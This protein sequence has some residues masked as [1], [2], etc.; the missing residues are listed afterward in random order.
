MERP[1]VSTGVVRTVV[2]AAVAASVLSGCAGPDYTYVRDDTGGT[3]FKV[4]ASWR[5]IDQKTLDEELFGDTDSATAQVVKQLVWTAAFDAYEE[6]SLLHLVRGSAGTDDRPFV[7]AK[8]QKLSEEEQNAASLNLLRVSPPMPVP[9]TEDQQK[10]FEASGL[11]GFEL[12]AD[13][14]LPIADGVRGIHTVY[15]YR[16]GNAV[17]TFDRTAYLSAD[18]TTAS[19]LLIR[20]SPAC[21]RQRAAEIGTVVKSFKVKHLINP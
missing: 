15:N 2:G 12:L 16:V 10:E 21:Y 4:P 1:R 5:Q 9:L 3:Y 13:E 19:T 18:G 14:V 7:F 11:T 17:Q 20:C 6:P 8:V